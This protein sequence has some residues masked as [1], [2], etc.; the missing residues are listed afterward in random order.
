MALPAVARSR[1]APSM[2]S[3]AVR[4]KRAVIR[5]MRVMVAPWTWFGLNVTV[6][7][8]EATRRVGFHP[9]DPTFAPRINRPM[10]G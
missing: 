2:V 4:V 3:Q 1:P 7:T 5:R 10:V 6:S 9:T 8:R